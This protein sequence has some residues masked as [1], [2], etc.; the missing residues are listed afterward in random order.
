M[1][2]ASFV[3]IALIVIISGM[4]YCFSVKKKK[5]KIIRMLLLFANKHIYM[6]VSLENISV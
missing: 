2:D 4:Y 1:K 6:N 3:F 5:K